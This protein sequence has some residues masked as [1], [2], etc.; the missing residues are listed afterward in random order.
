[1]DGLGKVGGGEGLHACEIGY[2]PGDLEDAVVGARA[3]TE[4]VDG[5][6]QKSP[7]I[8]MQ[9]TRAPQEPWPYLYV[10][11]DLASPEARLLYVRERGTF[12]TKYDYPLPVLLGALA[13]TEAV[14]RSCPP[15]SP[16]HRMAQ[17]LRRIRSSLLRHPPF[18]TSFIR[19]SS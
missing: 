15:R 9:L 18:T 2:G 6:L 14:T 16:H 8:P 3:Q 11:V 19:A 1:L 10:T 7:E 12:L 17:G 13:M 4:F 5:G